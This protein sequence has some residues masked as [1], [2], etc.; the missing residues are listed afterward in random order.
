MEATNNTP[1]TKNIIPCQY[2]VDVELKPETRWIDLKGN[3]EIYTDVTGMINPI[4]KEEWEEAYGETYDESEGEFEPG[5]I[6]L[7]CFWDGHNH[8]KIAVDIFSGYNSQIKLTKPEVLAVIDAP[9]AYTPV[10]AL[11]KDTVKNFLGEQK[12]EYYVIGTGDCRQASFNQ[13][14]SITT[15][16]A[17]E[18]FT[19]EW[20][21]EQGF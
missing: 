21:D 9:D 13:L 20:I 19:V 5:D 11:I 2:T 18:D 1:A 8:K 16:P 7:V 14:R 6:E 17:P 12:E 3:E 10:Y 15:P 4:T